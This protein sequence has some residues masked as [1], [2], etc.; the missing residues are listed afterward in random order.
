DETDWYSAIRDQL[1]KTSIDVVADVVAGPLLSGLI[2]ILGHG[3]RYVTAGAIANPNVTI[4]WRKI[5]LKQLDVLGSTLGTQK[6]AKDLIGYI[7]RGKVKP[8]LARTYPLAQI[9]QAQKDFKKKQ[10]FGKLVIAP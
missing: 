7:T 10:F 5:Y 4:D 6:E 2:E 3:G 1:G 8:L 9:V